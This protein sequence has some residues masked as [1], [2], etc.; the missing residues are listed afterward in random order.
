MI[1]IQKCTS[2]DDEVELAEINTTLLELK[3]QQQINNNNHNLLNKIFKLMDLILVLK[4]N[5]LLIILN[6][7]ELS[8]KMIKELYYYE[9]NTHLVPQIKY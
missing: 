2:G 5:L 3:N 4:Q 6:E 8:L 7:K 1:N 9:E